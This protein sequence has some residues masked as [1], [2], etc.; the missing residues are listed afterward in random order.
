MLISLALSLLASPDGS[1]ARVP[2]VAD[3][4][5]ERVGQ[6]ALRA[7]E[8]DGVPGLSIAVDRDGE[9]LLA[10]G[11]GYADPAR[12]VLASADTSYP[13]GSLSRQFTAAGILL[14][15][16]R[17]DLSL[18]DELTR[19]LPDFPT[20]GHTVRLRQLLEGT[21]G[22]PGYAALA[23]RHGDALDQAATAEELFALLRDAPFDF[24]P[25]EGFSANQPGYLLLAMVASKASGEP[26]CDF[27]RERIL[28]PLDLRSTR[29]CPDEGRPLGFAQACKELSGDWELEI[30]LAEGAGSSVLT[31]CSSV[32][33]LVRWERAIQ[34]E[35]LLDPPSIRA[36]TSTARLS[37]GSPTGHGFATSVSA[38][39]FSSCVAHTGGIGGFRVRLAFY[40]EPRL[41][42]VVLANCDSAQVERLEQ[43]VARAALDLLPLEVVDRRLEPEEIA[44]YTGTW[45]IATQ[46][47]RTFEQSGAL[48]FEDS[49]DP[50][51]RLLYQ[52]GHVFVSTSDPVLR[53]TFRVLGNRPAESFEMLRDGAVSIGTRMGQRD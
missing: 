3:T 10:Q 31:L 2:R 38:T 21:S 34:D 16:E 17:G 4:F 14:L 43:E 15:A 36:M 48:W 6:L 29:F 11:W 19:W 24:P 44:L 49:P 45:Q 46:R 41:T 51:F 28:E 26:Y 23:A 40:A 20:Q 13:I 33:D 39:D 30:P 32:K 18:D 37:D 22:I 47:V 35:I 53:I 5:A 9:L 27:V 12:G 7:I 1:T 8:Q 52:A 25:G 50:P 42:V